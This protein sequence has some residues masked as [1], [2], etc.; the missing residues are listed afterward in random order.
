ML[1]LAENS[2]LRSELGTKA[3]QRVKDVFSESTVTGA[4]LEFYSNVL[5]TVHR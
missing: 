4:V 2:D 5:S 3:Q 1:L